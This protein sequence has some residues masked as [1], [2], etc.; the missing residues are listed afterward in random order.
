MHWK[1]ELALTMLK[2]RE[3]TAIKATSMVELVDQAITFLGQ[4]SISF[5]TTGNAYFRQEC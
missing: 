2:G 5:H 1:D 4:E 3:R